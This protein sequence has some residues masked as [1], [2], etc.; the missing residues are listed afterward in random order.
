MCK[1]RS[2]SVLAYITQILIIE[3]NLAMADPIEILDI[4]DIVEIETIV[5]CGYLGYLGWKVGWI[6]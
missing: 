6:R 1:L 3:N 5:E 2:V 4:A